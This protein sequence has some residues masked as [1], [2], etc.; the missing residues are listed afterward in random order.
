MKVNSKQKTLAKTEGTLKNEE[1][2][3]SNDLC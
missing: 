2:R 3:G 1:L